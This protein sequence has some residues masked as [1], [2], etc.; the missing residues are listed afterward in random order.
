GRP[1]AIAPGGDDVA[2][3]V[4][5]DADEDCDDEEHAFPRFRRAACLVLD[6]PDPQQQQRE[7]DVHTH[8][9]AA[10]GADFEGPGHLADSTLARRQN[11][12][13]RMKGDGRRKGFESQELRTT[14]SAQSANA[15][16]MRSRFNSLRDSW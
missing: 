1:D 5:H 6:E 14:F 15:A 11:S 12:S 4:Q 16:M 8:F 13:T 9:G 7:G 2:E 10:E 3:L